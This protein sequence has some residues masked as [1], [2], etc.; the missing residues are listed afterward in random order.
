MTFVSLGIFGGLLQGV[1]CELPALI[2]DITPVS[3][4][5][6]RVGRNRRDDEP[7]KKELEFRTALVALTNQ[8][9]SSTLD[10]TFYQTALERTVELVPDAQGGSVLIRQDDGLF[11]FEAAAEFDF[12]VLSSITMTDAEMGKRAR[13][14]NIEKIHIHDYESRLSAEKVS[15]FRDAGKL[16]EIRATLSVPLVV[17]DDTMGYFNLDNFESAN[18]FSDQDMEIAQAIAAQVSVALYRL[19][20]EARLAKERAQFQHMAHHD[21]LTGLANRRLF[22]DSLNRSIARARRRNAQVGLLYVDMDDF[23]GINDCHGHAAGDFLLADIASRICGAIREGD[24]AARLGGD[25]FGVVLNDVTGHADTVAVGRKIGAALESAADFHGQ[26]LSIHAS[27]GAATY[28]E[29]A[30]NA[31]S[32]LRQADSRMYRVKGSGKG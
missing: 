7:L 15:R 27:I 8:L 20:L 6:V 30:E 31:E 1:D 16:D 18:A 12:E 19:M 23:K 13:R 10:S 5:I 26:L 29:H 28:P 24:L 22:L 4:T 17:D 32:L 3:P 14:A 25:E 21:F 9:L 11:R 2:I